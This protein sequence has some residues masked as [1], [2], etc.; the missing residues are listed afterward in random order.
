MDLEAELS[1]NAQPLDH[2]LIAVDRDRRL[3]LADE[4]MRRRASLAL[5]PAQRPQLPAGQRMR[6]RRACL[7]PA[8]VQDAHLEIDLLPAQIHELGRPE[9]VA[10]GQEDHRGVAMARGRM[11]QSLDLGLGQVLARPVL[12]VLFTAA[13]CEL[14][15]YCAAE[16]LAALAQRSW[17]GQ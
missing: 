15:E 17:P 3:A 5:Q 14:S 11:D 7:G 9:P 10:E 2:L 6:R 12:D 1:A 16:T 13:A 4:E 8:D